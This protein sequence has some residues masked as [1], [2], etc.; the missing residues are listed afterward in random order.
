[1][2]AERSIATKARNEFALKPI[3]VTR[4]GLERDHFN[5]W[6][7]MRLCSAHIMLGQ[8]QY[9]QALGTWRMSVKFVRFEMPLDL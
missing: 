9:E 4:R 3:D 6:A 1:M 8:A 7:W 2:R 5:R